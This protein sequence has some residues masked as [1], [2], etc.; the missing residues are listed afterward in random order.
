[1]N[2]IKTNTNS[3]IMKTMENL[4]VKKTNKDL[5]YEQKINTLSDEELADFVKEFLHNYELK[6]I[7]LSLDDERKEEVLIN[8]Q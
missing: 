6:N 5:E 7:L 8:I 2:A 1:M 4:P 3:I